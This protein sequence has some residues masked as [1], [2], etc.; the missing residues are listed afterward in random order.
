MWIFH[1]L[2]NRLLMA[3]SLRPPKS[4]TL[5]PILNLPSD[6]E[7]GTPSHDYHLVCRPVLLILMAYQTKIK[8]FLKRSKLPSRSMLADLTVLILLDRPKI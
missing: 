3:T 2:K 6:L 7:S 5:R 4:F 8:T 1:T